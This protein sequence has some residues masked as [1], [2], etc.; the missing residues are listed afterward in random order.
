[1]TERTLP[2]QLCLGA[3]DLLV[4]KLSLSE[5]GEPYAV[6]TSPMQ[7]EP[8]GQMRI[9]QGS[10]VVAKV[11]YVG[12]TV[13]A[14]GMDSHM[15]FAFADEN[16]AVPHFTLDSV[17]AHGYFAF[18]LDL[19]PR[20]DLGSNLSYMDTCFSPLTD[21]FNEVDKRE[22]FSRAE[23]SPRQRAIMSPWMLVHRATEDAFAQMSDAVRAYEEH[24][25]G[26]IDGGLPADV[27]AD[28]DVTSI[29][30]RDARNRAAIFNPDVDPVWAQIS[31]LLGAEQSESIRLQLVTNA[32]VQS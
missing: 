28:L 5:V 30:V 10:G 17:N 27:L 3:V 20:V 2:G 12:I 24:W 29:P 18:H 23:I 19:I 13:A 14:I 15:V 11:V 16:S 31:R 32:V 26:L 22:G 9:W 8:V 25:L 6:L 7:P 21:T 4:N 1:M